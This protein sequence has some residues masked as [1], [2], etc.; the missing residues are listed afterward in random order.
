MD[1]K[2]KQV[3]DLDQFR[4]VTRGVAK[5]AKL[6]WQGASLI[7]SGIGIVFNPL[8][9][10]GLAYKGAKYLSRLKDQNLAGGE[11]ILKGFKATKNI[12]RSDAKVKASQKMLGSAYLQRGLVVNPQ[13]QKLIGMG[14]KFKKVPK[15]ESV[16]KKINQRITKLNKS[17]IGMAKNL[18]DIKKGFG[19]T[20]AAIGR[21]ALTY[22][23]Y[24][25]GKSLLSGSNVDMPELEKLRKKQF[26]LQEL[27][28]QGR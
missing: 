22:Q 3:P 6:A 28:R 24:Q 2:I 12:L 23:T 1:K 10:V 5:G 20:G 7:G 9:K 19:Y 27:N 17:T 26:K 8:A 21:G 14:E 11:N 25:T 13:G 4:K 18:R 15:L 16:D